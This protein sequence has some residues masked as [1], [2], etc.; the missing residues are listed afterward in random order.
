MIAAAVAVG[1]W[2]SRDVGGVSKRS[3]KPDFGFPRSGFSTA[4]WPA[5]SPLQ[6]IGH[7][8][9]IANGSGWSR[10]KFV[11]CARGPTSL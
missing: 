4:C 7:V 6:C 9:K 1:K 8:G 11:K 10:G 2:E 3:G 5:A